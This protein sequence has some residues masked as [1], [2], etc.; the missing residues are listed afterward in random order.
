MKSKFGSDNGSDIIYDQDGGYYDEYGYYHD[1]TGGYY[2]EN[3]YYYDSEGGY[4]DPDGNYFDAEGGCYDTQGNYYPPE[5]YVEDTGSSRDEGYGR[6]SGESDDG[7]MFEDL[8]AAYEKKKSSFAESSS[9]KSKQGSKQTSK[10]T[11][12]KYTNQGKPVNRTTHYGRETD[13]EKSGKKRFRFTGITAVATV[14]GALVG[15]GFGA[16]IGA[17][18]GAMFLVSPVVSGIIGAI[19]LAIL[20]GAACGGSVDFIPGRIALVLLTIILI[21]VTGIYF[22]LRNVYNGPEAARNLM[23]STIQE[24]G[25]L[26]FVNKIFLSAEEIEEITNRN[27]MGT[28]DAEVDLGLIKVGGDAENT[29]AATD[30]EPAEEFDINGFELVEISGRTYLAKMM[31]VNDPSRVK[32]TTIFDGSWKEYGKT[33]DELVDGGNYLGGINGGEYQS[34]SNKGGQPKGLVV[35]DGEI[36][37]NNPQQGDVMVGF[38]RDNILIIRDVG[39][40]SA[41]ALKDLVIELDIRDAVTF[42]DIADGDDNHFTKLIINGESIPLSGNGSGAN[43]R[44]VIGQKADGTVLLLTTDGRG[45]GGHLGATAADIISI[46]Q[47]YGAVNVA[48]LDGGSSSCMYV[49]GEWEQ[50][51]V[52]LYY[53]NASWRLPLA[54]VVE[55]RD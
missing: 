40:M 38:N 55:R 32:L 42:K 54:F 39:G 25:Q 4:Y 10:Q 52:T 36:Q 20:L 51:S 1:A 5:D 24:T 30:G 35:C 18:L 15:A 47:E 9:S 50:T 29:E 16:A 33:L 31:I 3:G 48:N 17:V 37:Y 27:S 12:A 53:S 41:A 43:P 28:L 13:S 21:S 14:F 45:A 34:D 49:D 46:M 7:L 22:F 6:N 8:N 23:A 44:T 19:V 2:D 26:K 11:S